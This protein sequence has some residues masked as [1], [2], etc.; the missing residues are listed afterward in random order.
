MKSKL[1]ITVI[2]LL[3]SA[4]YTTRLNVPGA[5]PGEVHADRQWFA[6]AGA[7]SM[8]DPANAECEDGIAYVESG[9]TGTDFL[10]NVGLAVLGAGIAAGV[11]YATVDENHRNFNTIRATANAGGALAG[12]LIAPRTI[13]YACHVHSSAAEENQH[14]R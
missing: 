6:L 5:T 10:I 14:T 13:R 9:L 8:S 12:F 1:S 3:S 4:C 7:K 2:V 11:T